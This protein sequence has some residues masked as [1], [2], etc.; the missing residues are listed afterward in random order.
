MK[1]LSV[2]MTLL[3]LS[4]SPFVLD[5][6]QSGNTQDW[7]V[8]C[9][10]VMGGVSTARASQNENSIQ[11]KGDVS[12]ENNGGFASFRSPYSDFALG[13]FTHVKIKYRSTGMRMGF[14]LNWNREFW[15]PYFKYVLPITDGE[16]ETAEILLNDF[17]T[18]RLEQ[19]QSDKINPARLNDIIRFGFITSEKRAGSFEF[20]IQ[21]I[22]FY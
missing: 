16:W 22:T 7:Y 11:I 4:N 6:R 13:E 14:T 9:D 17:K 18:Y 1:I 5:F 10:S 20:E 2:I 8:L 15:L 3:F 12:L 21:E 19:V